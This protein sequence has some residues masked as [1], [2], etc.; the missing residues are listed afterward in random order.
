MTRNQNIYLYNTFCTYTL[1][2]DLI[3][4]YPLCANHNDFSWNIKKTR[5]CYCIND[6]T[7][8]EKK[9]H[10]ICQGEPRYKFDET[11]P[12]ISEEEEGEVAVASVAYR[13]RKWDLDNNIVLVSR[14]EHDAVLPTPN[15]ELQF[16]TI[17][18]LNEWDSKVNN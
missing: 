13:Y 11:N 7:E 16:L 10:F 2:I 9:C 1:T 14:C 17:K 18:A 4:L 8:Y 6:L 12:F 5:D 3:L 15:G